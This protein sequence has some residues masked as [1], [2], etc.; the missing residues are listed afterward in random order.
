MLEDFTNYSLKKIKDLIVNYQETKNTK[1]LDLLLARFDK[2]ILYVLYDLKRRYS[3]LYNEEMSEL[4]QTGLLGFYKGIKAF[5]THLDPTMVLLVVKAYIKSEIK[6]TYAYKNREIVGSLVPLSTRVDP[7]SLDKGDFLLQ[8]SIFTS[9][10]FS[11]REKEMIQMRFFEGYEVKD[12]AK[13]LNMPAPTAFKQLNRL[14]TRI[15]NMV[16]K[17]E[18]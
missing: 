3:Y 15:K 4:Y 1:A 18:K 9:E 10:N 5:K 17:E 2:Y 12:I 16:V 11:E 13:K 6:Q 14:F 8:H 7:F